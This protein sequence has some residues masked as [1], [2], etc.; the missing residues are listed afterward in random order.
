[1]SA[2]STAIPTPDPNSPVWNIY[3]DNQS[4]NLSGLNGTP[5]TLSMS[6][7]NDFYYENAVGVAVQGF[8]LG[9]V[10]ML[11]IVLLVVTPANKICKPI[12]LLN[13][14]A[15]I[16][17]IFRAILSFVQFTS[18]YQGLG[19]SFIPGDLAQYSGS[20]WAP[21][22]MEAILNT[23]F[24]FCIV[25]SLLLQVRVVFAGEPKTRLAFTV[26]G[27]LNVLVY[28]VWAITWEVM[29]INWEY[30]YTNYTPPW[31]VLLL[32]RIYFVSFIGV[33]CLIFLF[34]LG[35]TIYRRQKMGMSI[36]QFGP[37]QIVFIIFVQSLV[38]PGTA[39]SPL[40]GNVC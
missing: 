13:I 12:F 10:A 28:M 33:C 32:E 17:L 20:T 40:F 27:A 3:L 26:F 29:A 7:I 19:Q 35:V 36:R 6:N 38:G 21:Y 2:T 30:D 11:L 18:S 31:W 5:I 9:S 4:F 34:K 14:T 15:M 22:V 39:S 25:V 16:L 23:F 37:L 1:M 8:T 24:V